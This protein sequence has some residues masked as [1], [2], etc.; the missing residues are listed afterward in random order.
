MNFG[1]TIRRD[2][3]SPQAIIW[4]NNEMVGAVGFAPTQPE[5]AG[6]TDRLGSLDSDA[7]LSQECES[8]KVKGSLVTIF[9]PV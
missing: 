7:R 8:R 4:L 3:V 5:G 6:F 2:T 1:L 9:Q